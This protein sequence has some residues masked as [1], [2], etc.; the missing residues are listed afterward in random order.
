MLGEDAVNPSQS[1][2]IDGACMPSAAI[3]PAK[4]SDLP[5]S[6]A[7]TRDRSFSLDEPSFVS[8]RSSTSDAASGHPPP[9]AAYARSAD[10]PVG[11]ATGFSASESMTEGIQ[12]KLSA[13]RSSVFALVNGLY[14][15]HVGGGQ[16]VAAILDLGKEISDLKVLISKEARRRKKAH[17]Q[18]NLQQTRLP[19]HQILR[20]SEEETQI[21]M[22]SL[23]EQ[24]H[25]ELLG[26]NEALSAQD[27]SAAAIRVTDAN[28]LLE[29]LAPLV[30]SDHCP[31]ILFLAIMETALTRKAILHHRFTELSDVA[32]H[33]NKKNPFVS[34]LVIT[35][36]ILAT[37]TTKYHENPVQL[38]SLLKSL[39]NA[40]MLADVFTQWIV[41]IRDN[42][43]T[44]MTEQPNFDSEYSPFDGSS[45]TATR[46]QAY[47][48]YGELKPTVVGK[49]RKEGAS[50]EMPAQESN[51]LSKS[52]KNIIALCRFLMAQLFGDASNADMD[53]ERAVFVDTLTPVVVEWA[54]SKL[55][56]P[57]IPND[58]IGFD[59]L[60]TFK[61]EVL[62]FD[63]GLK[64]CG[65]IHFDQTDFLAL[66]EQ[67]PTLYARKRRVALL[68]KVREIIL[69]EDQNTEF[70]SE[71]T[72]RGGLSALN[73]F[74]LKS[75]KSG[76]SKEPDGEKG[77][78]GKQPGLGLSSQRRLDRK[79]R[80]YVEDGPLALHPCRVSVQAAAV[81]DMVYEIM[82]EAVE[83]ATVKADFAT[84]KEL[85]FCSR[86]ILDLFRSL[87]VVAL[88]DSLVDVPARSGVFLNDCNFIVHHLITL[89]FQHSSKIWGLENADGQVGDASK[90]VFSFADLVPLFRSTGEI[91]FRGQLRRQR[92]ILLAHIEEAGGLNKLSEDERL[93]KVEQCYKRAVFHVSGLA[94]VWKNILPSPFYLK[95]MGLLVESLMAAV[96]KEVAVAEETFALEK[97]QDTHQLRYLLGIFGKLGDCFEQNMSTTGGH[98]QQWR[99]VPIVQ[100][101]PSWSGYQ[102]K[103]AGLAT[104][105]V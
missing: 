64:D 99:K 35:F 75:S 31:Q 102:S 5:A 56:L 38:R 103:L 14:V 72:Q 50:A 16:A 104:L 34:E 24:V 51:A 60:D 80:G 23:L 18:S 39:H 87:A 48:K 30:E 13:L 55:F 4:E 74:A 17:L 59:R 1:A 7:A 29:E 33:F 47:V 49:R 42:F 66:I 41:G 97:R 27:L 46:L 9:A 8:S 62:E 81:V 6:T 53:A 69:N 82:N 37:P 105:T 89:G 73:P 68:E 21:E 57:A 83:F 92:D 25:T 95:V 101:V 11:A 91:W 98:T 36:R 94:R 63:R 54:L 15:T 100:C 85:F 76:K 20:R 12:E 32:L 90:A 40:S 52:L 61:Q 67:L 44:K 22:L 2:A 26:F 93:E 79:D 86:D 77:M 19:R 45:R 84:F 3:S 88:S 96:L 10:G 71:G 43:F 78:G 28:A 65:A 58:R 70:V